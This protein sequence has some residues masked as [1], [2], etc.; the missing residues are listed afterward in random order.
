MDLKTPGRDDTEEIKLYRR[1]DIEMRKGSNIDTISQTICNG[2]GGKKNI[3][4][5]DCCVTRLRCTV[6]K[7]EL[8]N[9]DLLNATGA[10]G[11]V[12]RGH[13]VQVIYG[14]QVAVIKSNLDD[15]LDS[16]PNEEYRESNIVKTVVISSPITG[17]VADLCTTPN[18]AFSQKMLGDGAVV[19]PTEAIVCAPD[20]GEIIFV[21]ETKH[22][23]GFLTDT[24]ISLLIHIG[25]DTV[26]LNGKGFQVFVEKGQKV[27]KGDVLMELDLAY[28]KEN[29]ASLASP[30][31][32][33][34]L[35]DGQT[36]RLLNTG[37]VSTGDALFAIDFK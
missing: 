32:C 24:G 8:V 15:Y 35:I 1:N 20:D 30:I 14:P 29:A 23:I 22:A 36:V 21:F 27:K 28:L 26:N 4:D 25:I 9:D 17:M 31:L 19:T 3:S 34:E 37:T 10:S 18:E 7:P 13:G 6:H 33:P 12:H 16:A 11:I 5:L 2:L